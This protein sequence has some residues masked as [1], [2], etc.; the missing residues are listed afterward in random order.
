MADADQPTTPSL[1]DLQ[2]WTWVMGRAQQMMLEAGLQA[3]TSS[4]LPTIPGVNDP[5]TL[6]RAGDFW[7]SSLELWQRFLEPGAAGVEPVLTA[8]DKRFKSEAWQQPLFDWI[9]RSYEM[10]AQHLL[11]QV[12]AAEGVDPKRREQLRFA[13]KA[14]VDAMSPANYAWTNPQVIERTIETRGENLLR[15]L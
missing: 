14:F 13:A 5:A 9:R 15:G 6:E 11:A 7:R 4:G 12:E 10:M 2:H 1:A 8:K 3:A